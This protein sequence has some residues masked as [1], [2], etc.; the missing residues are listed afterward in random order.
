MSGTGLQA[1]AVAPLPLY[2]RVLGRDDVLHPAVAALRAGVRCTRATGSFTVRRGRS[3]PARLIAWLLHL[4]REGAE[5]SSVLEIARHG[6]VKHWWRR[7]GDDAVVESRQSLGPDGRL[8]EH[9][10][11]VELSPT[12]QAVDGALI[13]T[14]RSAALRFGPLRCSLPARFTPHVDASARSA[15]GGAVAVRVRIGLPVVGLLLAFEGELVVD[16]V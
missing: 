13:V 8:Y 7:F 2:T 6:G 1:A 16:D 9:Y 11:P 12:V 3:A 10:G 4:P 5:V 14:G 15:G